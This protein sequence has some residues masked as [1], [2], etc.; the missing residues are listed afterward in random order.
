[1]KL[2]NATVGIIAI[3]L[4]SC[5]DNQGKHSFI[6][7]S[8]ME[9]LPQ[10]TILV[11]NSI[12]SKDSIHI[13]FESGFDSMLVRVSTGEFIREKLLN[14]DRVLGVAARIS[15]PMSSDPIKILFDNSYR[16]DLNPKGRR[17]IVAVNIDD[18]QVKI[19]FEDEAPIYY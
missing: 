17:N 2:V 3:C 13:H 4:M 15:V 5:A 6:S 1:M 16:I 7:E 9:T 11:G 14:T 8:V 19:G 10:D 12:L 18:H